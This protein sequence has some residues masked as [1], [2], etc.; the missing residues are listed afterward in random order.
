MVPSATEYAILTL[1]LEG[2]VTTWT[3]AEAVEG[4]GSFGFDVH[5]AVRP[6][7]GSCRYP[8]GV[9]GL[10]APAMFT[11]DDPAKS[12]LGNY[13]APVFAYCCKGLTH[14]VRHGPSGPSV[15]PDRARHRR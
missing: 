8:A 2:R 9:A 3:F 14:L 15:K 13:S 10:A 6:S 5:D 1:D 4:G 12:R 11:G 7:S